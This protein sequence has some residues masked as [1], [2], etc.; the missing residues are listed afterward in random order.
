MTIE[1]AKILNTQPE[2]LSFRLATLTS[3]DLLESFMK[4][5]TII[6]DLIPRNSETRTRLL[7]V[8]KAY[9]DEFRRRLADSSPTELREFAFL[10]QV[11]LQADRCGDDTFMT[12]NLLRLYTI[13]LKTMK[14]R[15]ATKEHLKGEFL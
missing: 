11:K 12:R 15:G 4:S 6:G 2:V 5:F 9:I 7:E 10:M 3:R 8:S 1:V 13:V 14:K